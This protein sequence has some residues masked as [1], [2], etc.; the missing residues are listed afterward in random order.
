MSR[1]S[2]RPPRTWATRTFATQKPRT[3]L[4]DRL[5]AA[6]EGLRQ[7]DDAAAAEEAA[8]AKLR[9]PRSY[10]PPQRKVG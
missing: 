8:R 2:P 9:N 10:L 1:R 7:A 5:T 3:L 4:G 6:L